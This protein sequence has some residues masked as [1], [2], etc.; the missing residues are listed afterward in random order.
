ME[1]FIGDT[2]GIYYVNARFLRNSDK[3]DDFCASY[4][5][6]IDFDK[7]AVRRAHKF[8]DPG[9]FCLDLSGVWKVF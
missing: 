7:Y 4:L 9:T 1:V 6:M 5:Q 8:V 2:E 3:S